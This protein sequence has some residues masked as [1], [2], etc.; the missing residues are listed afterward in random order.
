MLRQDS[1]IASTGADAD[2]AKG[3][4]RDDRQAQRSSKDLAA[5]LAM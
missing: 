3:P 5:T 1:R 4:H 2:E